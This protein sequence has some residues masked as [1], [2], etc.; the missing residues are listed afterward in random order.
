MV[1]TVN[2]SVTWFSLR[3]WGASLF[4]HRTLG[5]FRFDL[6]NHPRY[7]QNPASKWQNILWTH[8]IHIHHL[9]W[10]STNLSM[11]LWCWCSLPVTA[12]SHEALPRYSSHALWVGPLRNSEVEKEQCLTLRSTACAGTSGTVKLSPETHG[13]FWPR[14]GSSF[15]VQIWQHHPILWR[16]HWLVYDWLLIYGYYINQ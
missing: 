12:M 10:F 16:T 8:T 9:D 4:L 7:L 6:C 15:P 3:I 11:C 13:F 1:N 5:V 14:N 2:T